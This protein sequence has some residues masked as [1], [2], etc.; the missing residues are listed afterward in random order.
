MWGFALGEWV[1][2]TAN[3][4]VFMRFTYDFSLYSALTL[5]FLGGIKAIEFYL[6]T[7]SKKVNLNHANMQCFT[8]LNSEFALEGMN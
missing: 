3:A 7:H 5:I 6:H 8:N 4:V 2:T 1:Q